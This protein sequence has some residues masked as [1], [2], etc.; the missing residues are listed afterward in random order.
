MHRFFFPWLAVFRVDQYQRCSDNLLYVKYSIAMIH[1]FRVKNG[2]ALMKISWIFF[3]SSISIHYFHRFM[4]IVIKNR[5]NV[6][7]YYLGTD[8][9]A[10]QIL[11]L[12]KRCIYQCTINCFPLSCTTLWQMFIGSIGF[13]II[14]WAN[15]AEV[16]HTF[17]NWNE[18]YRR[19]FQ[20]FI[21]VGFLVLKFQPSL[22]TKSDVKFCVLKQI[23]CIGT[24]TFYLRT[25]CKWHFFS[26]KKYYTMY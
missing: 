8:C 1:F 11:N 9:S 12:T 14:K 15:K 25:L 19:W 7:H 10:N 21:F 22:I 23:I 2:N 18:S 24:Y 16:M 5:P 17:F 6:L 26:M 4:Y 13:S 3:L 20:F